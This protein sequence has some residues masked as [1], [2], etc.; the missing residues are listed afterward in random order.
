VGI[1]LENLGIQESGQRWE[2]G[3]GFGLDL[4]WGE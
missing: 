1:R 2:L 3:V 4:R